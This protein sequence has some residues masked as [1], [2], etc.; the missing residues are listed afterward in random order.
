M[1]YSANSFELDLPEG[2]VDRSH[3]IL[4][5]PA[6]YTAEMF[7]F[8]VT[9]DELPNAVNLGQLVDTQVKAIERSQK[10]FK[11]TQAKRVGAFKN[12]VNLELSAFEVGFSY[13][14]QGRMISQRLVFVENQP[15]KILIFAGTLTGDWKEVQLESWAKLLTGLKFK[16]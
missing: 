3:H 4:T 7:N 2:Y 9:R 11:I 13:E 10:N 16:A 5:P 6:A 8:V 1:K 12:E 15:G 14:A